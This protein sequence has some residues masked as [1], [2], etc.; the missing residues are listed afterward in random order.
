MRI[1]F[2]VLSAP[3]HLQRLQEFNLPVEYAKHSPIHYADPGNLPELETLRMIM[4]RGEYYEWPVFRYLPKLKKLVLHGPGSGALLNN[5]PYNQLSELTLMR[6]GNLDEIIDLLQS[7]PNLQALEVLDT[8]G[9]PPISQFLMFRCLHRLVS[10]VTLIRHLTVPAIR[11]LELVGVGYQSGYDNVL[12]DLFDRSEKC[13]HLVKFR[14]TSDATIMGLNNVLRTMPS[15]VEFTAEAISFQTI[16]MDTFLGL[17]SISSF[18]PVVEKIS[19]AISDLN[20]TRA[21]HHNLLSVLEARVRKGCLKSFH[22][23]IP[24]PDAHIDHIDV[25]RMQMLRAQG[26][27]LGISYGNQQLLAG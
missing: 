12:R 8:Q 17:L 3:R 23:K 20:P 7:C 2:R 21:F 11:E 9:N 19:L 22:L 24:A 6:R 16:F 1:L 13:V 14:I 25:V 18:L 15:L 27:D 10:E 4:T 26:L 5:L